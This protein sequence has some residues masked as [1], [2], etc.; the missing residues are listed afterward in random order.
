MKLEFDL[1]DGWKVRVEEVVR[2]GV[3]LRAVLLRPDGSAFQCRENFRLYRTAKAWA[4]GVKR[5]VT[6]KT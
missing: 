3:T 1:G 6:E 4:A 5:R 2:V